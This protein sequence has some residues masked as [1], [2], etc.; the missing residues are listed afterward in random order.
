MKRPR[1]TMITGGC[2]VWCFLS[3]G[4]VLGAQAKKLIQY[5]WGPPDTQYV[6]DHWQHIEELPFD[7]V[8]IVVAIDREAW[9]NGETSTVNQ[10]GWQVMGAKAFQLQ[11]FHE[12]IA[13]LQ[14]TR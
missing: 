8:G 7:G 3:A 9:R 13:D 4:P 10:L 11:A 2:L 5:G 6:R 14:A 12:A 1:L